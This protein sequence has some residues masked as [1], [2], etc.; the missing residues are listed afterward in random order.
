MH[1]FKFEVYD[2]SKVGMPKRIVYYRKQLTNSEWCVLKNVSKT[3]EGAI[4]VLIDSIRREM[5]EHKPYYAYDPNY[6]FEWRIDTP[7]ETY[8][9]H[10][11][12]C[13]KE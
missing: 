7:E 6:T 4:R 8:R 10:E 12:G 2:Y 13:K 3:Q 5:L 11:T 9:L 1:K